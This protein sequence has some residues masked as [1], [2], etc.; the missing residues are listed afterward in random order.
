MCM[1]RMWPVSCISI[2]L[3]RAILTVCLH[4]SRTTL[5]A[6]AYTYASTFHGLHAPLCTMSH[7]V[8]STT[9]PFTYQAT[10]M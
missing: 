1:S 6:T 3:I 8:T 7:S 9:T 4:S 5:V 2:L 10:F